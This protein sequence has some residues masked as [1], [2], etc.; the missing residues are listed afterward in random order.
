MLDGE[1]LEFAITRSFEHPNIVQTLD[2]AFTNSGAAPESQVD[3]Q[4]AVS[5]SSQ[6]DTARDGEMWMLH[7][8]CDSGCLQ[9]S[10][11]LA[12]RLGS[13]LQPPKP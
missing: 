1:P 12:H 9:V 3:Q 5:A 11:E 2:Y 4:H 7:E 6:R 8:F 10:V 13:L